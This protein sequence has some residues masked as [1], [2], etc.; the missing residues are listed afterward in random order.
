MILLLFHIER[1]S[2]HGGDLIGRNL[3]TLFK[4]AEDIFSQFQDKLKESTRDQSRIV[5]EIERRC[6]K[7]K[8]LCI[9]LD[10]MFS[11]A[12][13]PSGDA[14]ETIIETTEKCVKAVQQKWNDLH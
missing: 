6:N 12:R 2:Y 9:L 8:E 4:N 11:L 3:L 13:T 7:T 10:Y 14:N 1:A 5:E